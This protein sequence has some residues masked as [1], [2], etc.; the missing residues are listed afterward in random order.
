VATPNHD[1]MYGF[2]PTEWRHEGS[3]RHDIFAYDPAR[4]RGDLASLAVPEIMHQVQTRLDKERAL[5]GDTALPMG[6]TFTTCIHYAA[7]DLDWLEFLMA[8]VADETR[9]DDLLDR[10][11]AASTKILRAHAQTDLEVM[12]THDD[13][14]MNIGV[15]QSPRWLRRHLFPRYRAILQPMRDRG[16]PVLFATDGNFLEVASDLVDA[17]AGGFFLDTPCIGLAA[18]VAA[19][20]PDLVFFTGPAPSTMQLGSP[21]Q[22]RAEISAMADIARDLPRFFFHMPGGFTHNTPVANVVAFYEACR[23]YGRR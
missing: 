14:A 2:Q 23:E 17:G 15:V 12:F 9:I 19:V 16:V 10:F 20:G 1:H 13:I 21:Q 5:V 11:Q 7:E 18:L 3:T 4:D 6:F 22:I 8:C